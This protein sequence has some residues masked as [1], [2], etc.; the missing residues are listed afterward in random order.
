MENVN[1]PSEPS[2]STSVSRRVLVEQT[3]TNAGE[4]WAGWWRKELVRQGR[5][6]AGG[7]PG[8]LSE[9]RAKVLETVLPEMRK[10]GM[11]ELSFDEQELAA[12]TLY[13]TAR[14]RWLSRRQ[15]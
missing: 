6:A 9:A 7:W 4:V 14:R 13:A 11:G 12:K 15:R 2:G 1:I 8:T 3:A 5:A 10:R